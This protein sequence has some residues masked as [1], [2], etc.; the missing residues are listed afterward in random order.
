M[1]RI[2]LTV[3]FVVV[4]F[5]ASAI[6]RY[7]IGSMTCDRVHAII[8]SEGAAILHYRSPR[9]AVALY[10]RYVSGR[11]YCRRT[12]YIEQVGLP[13]SDSASCPVYKCTQIYRGGSR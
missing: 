8:Q 13:T 6:S 9:N 2:A 12:Q 4:A 7:D 5:G 10:D 11:N 3:L 1:K